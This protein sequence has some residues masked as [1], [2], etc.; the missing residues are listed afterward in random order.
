AGAP[1][2]LGSHGSR[3]KVTYD[4]VGY[5]SRLDELQAAL[6]RVLLPEL[7]GW[8]DGRRAAGRHY[9]EAGLGELVK[10]PTP[11]EGADPAWHLYVIRHRL[12]DRL[13]PALERVGIGQR[14]YYPTPARA[15]GRGGGDR[16]RLRPD[17]GAVRAPRDRQHAHRPPSR[18]AAGRQGGRAGLAVGG[19]GPVGAPPPALRPGA[20]ARVQRRHGGGLPAARARHH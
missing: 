10:P 19:A 3:D 13:G 14:A 17:A 16:P 2:T 1:R 20:G 9:L 12:V 4:E 7:D 11:V 8:A 15:R 6:L 18:R 5:N